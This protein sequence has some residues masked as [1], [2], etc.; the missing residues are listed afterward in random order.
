MT[1]IKKI[2]SITFA[3]LLLSVIVF[4]ATRIFASSSDYTQALATLTE[5]EQKAVEANLKACKSRELVRL[6]FLLEANSGATQPTQDEITNV[7]QRLLGE[8]CFLEK[9]AL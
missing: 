3:V 7:K 2:I 8:S 9:A 5:A 1:R 4:S 6:Q